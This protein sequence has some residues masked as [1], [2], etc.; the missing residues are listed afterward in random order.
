MPERTYK[1]VDVSSHFSD[2]SGTKFYG[3]L[4]LGVIQQS[5]LQVTTYTQLAGYDEGGRLYFVHLSI[6]EKIQKLT[7]LM[8]S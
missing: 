3:I 4:L 5:A 1:R 6:L 8:T 2:I 7:I